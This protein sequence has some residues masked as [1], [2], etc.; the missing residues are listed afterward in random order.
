[1]HKGLIYKLNCTCISGRLSSWF[2]SYLKDR[3]VILPGCRSFIN[4]ITAGVPQG[5]VLGP[6]LLLVYINDN[7]IDI[8]T[9]IRLLADD[10]YLF[11]V[12]E[13]PVTA[14]AIFNSDLEKITSWA[15]Q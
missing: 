8:N 11:I 3:R 10:T 2:T 9:N 13:D 12:V 14:S 6:L 4:F 1:L 7:V 5:S 15:E